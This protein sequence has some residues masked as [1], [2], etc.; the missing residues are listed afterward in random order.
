MSSVS[1]A[2][3]IPAVGDTRSFG[4]YHRN[5]NYFGEEYSRTPGSKQGTRSPGHGT[6]LSEVSWYTVCLVRL[7]VMGLTGFARRKTLMKSVVN[8]GTG[9]DGSNH[10]PTGCPSPLLQLPPPQTGTLSGNPVIAAVYH[11]RG[12]GISIYI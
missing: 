6:P 3:Q 1:Y 4:D 5:R 11:A 9:D 7:W 2:L 8:D 10:I 12:Q